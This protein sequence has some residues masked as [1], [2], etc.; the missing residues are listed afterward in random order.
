M[1]SDIVPL[2]RLLKGE[3][4]R[5]VKEFEDI[6]SANLKKYYRSSFWAIRSLSSSKIV[7][8]DNGPVNASDSV[9][10][11]DKT[12]EFRLYR[13]L[14]ARDSLQVAK[15][16]LEYYPELAKSTLIE[17]AKYQ[18]IEYNEDSEEEPGRIPHEIRDEKDPIAKK[19][20]DSRHW[21]FPYYGSVD[22][23]I[24][25][26][27]LSL[28]YFFSTKQTIFL[29]NVIVH[30]SGNSI[31]I[32]GSLKAT[33]FWLCEKIRITQHGL[34]WYTAINPLGIKN[35]V[36]KD[37]WDS[38]FYHDGKVVSHR[39]EIAS[40]EVQIMALEAIIKAEDSK[41]FSESN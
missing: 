34:V 24:L 23:I 12:P 5:L 8:G 41:V 1:E 14:F 37:S 30:N 11:R 19:L 4:L 7:I 29:N 10:W 31:T 3:L 22:S 16:L 40:L 27:I 17:L 38:Y 36:W 2:P 21:K 32:A 9:I 25:Y 18:G 15:D 6:P 35:Q 33:L 28:D 13:T 20:S 26:I 39:Y